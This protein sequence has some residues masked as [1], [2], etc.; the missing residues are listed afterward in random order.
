[1][2]LI[3]TQG[4]LSIIFWIKGFYSLSNIGSDNTAAFLVVMLCGPVL[5]NE[6]DVAHQIEVV[7]HSD[8]LQ[9]PVTVHQIVVVL[10]H[11][12]HQVLAYIRIEFIDVLC[13]QVEDQM[14]ASFATQ[15]NNVVEVFQARVVVANL[16]AITLDVMASQFGPFRVIFAFVV[17]EA[18]PSC[19]RVPIVN[20]VPFKLIW[21]NQRVFTPMLPRQRVQFLF[22]PDG[23]GLQS[24]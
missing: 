23:I 3:K 21:E 8:T 2:S 16:K 4:L 15:S 11:Q 1:M 10:F 19:S 20:I 14:P 9:I 17:V 6:V 18:A 12:E 7:N 24:E 22:T 5:I 13:H